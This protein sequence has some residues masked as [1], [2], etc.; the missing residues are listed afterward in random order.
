MRTPHSFFMLSPLQK[1]MVSA[2]TGHYKGRETHKEYNK[3][4]DGTC[5]QFSLSVLSQ[6][7][8]IKRH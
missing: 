8:E 3:T 6:V 7:L 1:P 2:Y 5:D 4:F